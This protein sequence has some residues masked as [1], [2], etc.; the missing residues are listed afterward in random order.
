MVSSTSADDGAKDWAQCRIDLIV[1]V[2]LLQVEEEAYEEAEEEAPKDETEIQEV[3]GNLKGKLALSSA[4]SK[5]RYFNLN[6]ILIAFDEYWQAVSWL[7]L[8]KVSYNSALPACFPFHIGMEEEAY[9]E[10]EEEAPKDETEIQ[11]D[12]TF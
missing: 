12:C 3:V 5:S 7:F 6:S 9:E 10:V 2:R 1:F 4:V 8:L 11:V